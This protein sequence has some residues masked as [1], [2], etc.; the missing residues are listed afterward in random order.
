MPPRKKK[1][2]IEAEYTNRPPCV[3]DT[4]PI[5][6]FTDLARSLAGSRLI[7]PFAAVEVEANG[8]VYSALATLHGV[9]IVVTR[10]DAM[11]A[12]IGTVLAA[13]LVTFD[14]LHPTH[15]NS[16]CLG[17]ATWAMRRMAYNL[18]VAMA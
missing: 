17:L 7:T 16:L 11:P 2:E 3:Y 4:V 18:P 14:R 8:R 10:E 5:G 6:V 12:M 1:S 15:R 13:P 9:R